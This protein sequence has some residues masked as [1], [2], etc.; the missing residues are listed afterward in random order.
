MRPPYLP[1]SGH[2]PENPFDHRG[3]CVRLCITMCCHQLPVGRC[4]RNDVRLSQE[5]YFCQHFRLAKKENTPKSAPMLHVPNTLRQ[6]PDSSPLPC[7]VEAEQPRR[8]PHPCRLQN[9][10]TRSISR[11]NVHVVNSGQNAAISKNN[12]SD[13]Q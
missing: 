4:P 8:Y 3:W 10:R 7:M 1:G 11:H 9:L 6:T 2:D 12:A 5:T 13:H